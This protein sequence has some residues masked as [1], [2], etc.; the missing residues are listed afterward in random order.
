ML[1]LTARAE[2]TLRLMS[3]CQ[4]RDFVWESLISPGKRKRK[5]NSRKDKACVKHKNNITKKTDEGIQKKKKKKKSKF[6]EAMQ[7]KKEKK[8]VKKNKTSVELDH[9]FV[10]T[11]GYSGASGPF[12][13]SKPE[14]SHPCSTEKI[15]P[16]DLTQDS[17]RTKRKKK[18]AWDL[19]PG[20]IHVKRPKFVSSSPK[21]NIFS[22]E[23]AVR[24]AESCSQVTATSQAH[25]ND[26]Q[27]TADDINSQDLFITQKK[28]RVSPSESSSGEA[29]DKAFITSPTPV[30]Q[31]DRRL[32]SSGVQVEQHEGSN[33]HLQ[34]SHFY[35]HPKKAKEH[36][37]RPKTVQVV[38]IEEEEEKGLHLAQQI[39]KKKTLSFQKQRDLNTNLIEEKKASGLVHV[40]PS[41]VNPYLDEPAVVNSSLYVTKSDKYYFSSRQQSPSHLQNSGGLSLLPLIAKASIST[42]TE[43]F[44]TTE[45]SSYLNFCQKRVVTI[46]SESLKPLDL[47]LPRRARKDLPSVNEEKRNDQK[48]SSL[49]EKTKGN[50]HKDPSMRPSRSSEMKDVEV[51]KEPSGRQQGSVIAQGKGKTPTPSPQSESEAKSANS[52][53]DSEPPSCTGK[54]DLTQVRAVQMR[55]NESF[56][57]KTKGEGQS[58]R[59]ESP[60]MKLTQGREMKSRKSH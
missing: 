2:A 13:K 18:V 59:P 38:L 39:P 43:N 25:D 46:C 32:N 44:F 28:F 34:Q 21:E 5:K 11:Q 30:T 31:R 14:S 53:E 50:G 40:K 57:F 36:L 37:Q 12:A 3:D 51:K 58:L 55:L 7:G 15:K 45:L 16:D 35:Q 22:E 60:L 23:E 26:S 47:S 9:N 54:P 8:K 42:Q 24:D 1:S 33:I 20:Y 29:S 52:S 19:S 27:C 17:K 10:F 56:F 41:V 49:P 4:E 48:P 6:T